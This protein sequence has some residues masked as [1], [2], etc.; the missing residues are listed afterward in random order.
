MRKLPE[1]GDSPGYGLD[2]VRVELFLSLLREI[3]ETD[4][5]AA[6][7]IGLG[8]SAFGAPHDL[9]LRLEKVLLKAADAGEIYGEDRAVIEKSLGRYEDTGLAQVNDPGSVVATLVLEDDGRLNGDANALAFAQASTDVLGREIGE[10]PEARGVLL[11][12]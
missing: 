2:N 4:S 10:A 6:G 7:K 11:V 9:A 8:D 5:H 1:T 3:D 12:T